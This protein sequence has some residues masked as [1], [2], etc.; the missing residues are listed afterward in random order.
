M[1][2]NRRNRA[3]KQSDIPR[4][5]GFVLLWRGGKRPV[6][7]C[8]LTLDV[9]STEARMERVTCH[10]SRHDPSNNRTPAAKLSFKTNQ[11]VRTHRLE[12]VP[13]LWVRVQHDHSHPRNGQGFS[14]RCFCSCANITLMRKRDPGTS[15]GRLT[16][17]GKGLHLE[18]Q[19][20]GAGSGQVCWLEKM[21]VSSHTC[22]K[23][24]WEQKVA[25]GCWHVLFSDG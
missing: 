19:D 3:H 24:C 2:P 13:S 9:E 17:L 6:L 23:C 11:Y 7:T 25:P 1:I 21:D 8:W 18:F 4:F 15:V 10:R 22:P 12:R 16:F 14:L 20:Q 5:G